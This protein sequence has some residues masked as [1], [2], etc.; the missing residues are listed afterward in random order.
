MLG[1][2]VELKCVVKAKPPP[3]V[4]FWRDHE[5]KEPVPLGANYEM[6]TDVNSDVSTSLLFC[7]R[8]AQQLYFSYS[9]T[10]RH[11]DDYDI[12]HFAFDQ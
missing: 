2:R 10:G 8:T 4:I 5:G 7:L 1:E 9:H 6:T 3:Q 12:D 11:A